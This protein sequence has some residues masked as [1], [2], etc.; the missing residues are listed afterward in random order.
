MTAGLNCSVQILRLIYA[1]DEVGGSYPTGTILHN[2][3]EARIDEEPTDTAFLQ[4][5]LETKKI[6]SA[7][8][9]GHNLTLRE[10]DEV[11][12]VSP[13][14]HKYYGK[15]FRIMSHT[16]SSNHPAQKRNVYILKMERSQI[17]HGEVYQ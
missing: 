8:L 13:P 11:V 3:V 17:A 7:M 2:Y 1:D 10:Q 15:Y 6:F 4:Q 16:S 9:W 5:G 14:N 12:V